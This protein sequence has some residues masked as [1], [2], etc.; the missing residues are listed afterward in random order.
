MREPALLVEFNDSSLRIGSAL[1]QFPEARRAW[2]QALTE[3]FA[4]RRQRD[5]EGRRGATDPP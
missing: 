2:D 1:G 4:A 3:A 5:A